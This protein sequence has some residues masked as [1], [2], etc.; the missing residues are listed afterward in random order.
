[1]PRVSCIKIPK[2]KTQAL[3]IITGGLKL[4][5]YPS[6]TASK[7]W[8]HSRFGREKHFSNFWRYSYNMD[9]IFLLYGPSLNNYQYAENSNHP[10]VHIRLFFPGINTTETNTNNHYDLGY[11]TLKVLENLYPEN[12]WL[13]IWILMVLPNDVVGKVDL[14]ITVDFCSSNNQF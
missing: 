1:M 10:C 13:R 4:L 2:D 3:R 5:L 7:G 11:N 12:T 6:Q 9:I 14:V 8:N